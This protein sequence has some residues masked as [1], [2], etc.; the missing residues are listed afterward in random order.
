MGPLSSLE[1][2][3]LALSSLT[4]ALL[5][6]S[7]SAAPTVTTTYGPIE[8]ATVDGIDGYLGIPFAA[9]PS[10]ALRF[11][12]P[13]AHAGWS[14]PRPATAAGAKCVQGS[15]PGP[16]PPSPCGDWCKEHG[17]APDECGCGVCGSFGGCTFSCNAAKSSPAHPLVKCPNA[18]D[19]A[20]AL[21]DADP[22]DCLFI[23]AFA[24]S[25]AAA[26]AQPAAELKPVLVHIH[27]GGFVGGAA[28]TAWNM[29]KT[30]GS[31]VF[32]IQYR[33]GVMGFFST[34]ETP[35]H[36]GMQDQQF[37]LRWVKD[38]A[39]AFG[40]D[41]SRVMIFG[42]SA[43]GASVAGHLVLPDSAGLYHAAGI[44]SPGGHQGWM[45]DVRRSVSPHASAREIVWERSEARRLLMHRMTTGCRRR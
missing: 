23:N 43:G 21:A 45:G 14:A 40:G 22:E 30:T 17:H 12:P 31:V 11:K 28:T 38:N 29:S 19:A 33:L 39:R 35:D 6:R 20:A 44:E 18:T 25:A 32:S 4:L 2:S 1:L 41:A 26:T 10:G 3:S 27:G 13:T 42:C 5:A 34:G 37:A 7:A 16:R 15:L 9:P 8:G 36:L 24:P